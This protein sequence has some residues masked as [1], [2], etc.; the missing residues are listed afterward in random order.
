VP[1]IS[2]ARPWLEQWLAVAV[3]L[4]QAMRKPSRGSKVMRAACKAAN[5]PEIT[6]HDLRHC[7]AIHLLR[8]G[9]ELTDVALALGD[10]MEVTQR[11]YTGFAMANSAAKRMA[12]G[13]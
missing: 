9:R 8:L 5:V 2:A 4:K 13:I 11:Y 6:F 3:E 1:V 12:S 10:G 7:Y